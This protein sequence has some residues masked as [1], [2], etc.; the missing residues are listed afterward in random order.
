MGC[1]TRRSAGASGGPG[2]A[3]PGALPS[4]S[5]I[6]ETALQLESSHLSENQRDVGLSPPRHGGSDSCW[7][8][9]D[10]AVAAAAHATSGRSMELVPTNTSGMHSAR[11]AWCRSLARSSSNCGRNA[12]STTTLTPVRVG[13]WSGGARTAGSEH[14]LQTRGQPPEASRHLLFQQTVCFISKKAKAGRNK[15][16]FECAQGTD[17]A[18]DLLTPG[19]HDTATA[20]GKHA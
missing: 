5:C 4:S 7:S 13:R 17:H 11:N 20:S 3:P 10:R 12:G 1:S 2:V 6:E 19:M 8:E 15:F 18:D 14:G 16:P 9:N